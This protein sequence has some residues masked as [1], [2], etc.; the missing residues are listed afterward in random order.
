M[1]RQQRA[2]MLRPLR[3]THQVD[4]L[5]VDALARGQ[6]LQARLHHLVRAF[7][8]AGP[9]EAVERLAHLRTVDAQQHHTG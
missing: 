4:L 3:E 8:G 9:A 6:L 7:I 1:L 2:G 5:A